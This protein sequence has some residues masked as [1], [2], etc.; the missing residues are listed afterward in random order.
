MSDHFYCL[1]CHSEVDS[2]GKPINRDA[3]LRELVVANRSLMETLRMLGCGYGECVAK[4]VGCKSLRRA[5]AA[6]KGTSK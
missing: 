5:Q 1:K 6:M 4:C 2:N 3:L